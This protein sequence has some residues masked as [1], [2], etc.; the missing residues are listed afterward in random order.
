M[1]VNAIFVKGCDKAKNQHCH[2]MRGL[3]GCLQGEVVSVPDSA[4]A[5]YFF[6]ALIFAQRAL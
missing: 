1:T 5:L 4:T 6:V 2:E 3:R